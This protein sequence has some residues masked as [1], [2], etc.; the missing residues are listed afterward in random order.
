ML[1]PANAAE[2]GQNTPR[3][4]VSG[5]ATPAAILGFTIFRF[6]SMST[7]VYLSRAAQCEVL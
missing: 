4:R 5:D 1:A 7:F 6:P 2:S 3:H